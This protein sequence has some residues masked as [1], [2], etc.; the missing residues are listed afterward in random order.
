MGYI[1]S[2]YLDVALK[3][4]KGILDNFIEV[5]KDGLVTIIP[6]LCRS[7]V[8]AERIIVQETMIIILMKPFAAMIRKQ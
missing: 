7:Q 5:D 1:D 8:G 3:G 6:S 4:Y 2:S